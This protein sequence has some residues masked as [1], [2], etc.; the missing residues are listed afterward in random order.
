MMFQLNAMRTKGVEAAIRY[1]A[2]YLNATVD[3]NLSGVR[4][5]GADVIDSYMYCENW[6]ALRYLNEL[7]SRH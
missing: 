1:L 6:S 5:S 2:G 4:L 3:H 7:I